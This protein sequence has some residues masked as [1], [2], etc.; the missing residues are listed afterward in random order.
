MIYELHENCGVIGVFNLS[1]ESAL[2]KI[3]WGLKALNHRG[4]QSYGLLTYMDR[5][6]EFK[7]FKDRGLV[8]DLKNPEEWVKR[9]PGNLG[10]G[11]VRYSTS[12]R[13]NKESLLRGTQPFI[14]SDN[15]IEF[16]LAFNGNIVNTKEL[17]EEI[18]K[19]HPNFNCWCDLQYIGCLLYTS[20]SPRDR[21]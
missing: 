20:P 7:I 12:G 5:E 16:G 3:Y 21:G 4:H 18:R 19:R 9:L 14:F 1:S 8:K 17:T 15:G 6:K 2:P 10:I 13:K 11:N